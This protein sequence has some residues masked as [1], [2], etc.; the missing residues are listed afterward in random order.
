M[1]GTPQEICGLIH[2]LGGLPK[3]QELPLSYTA[4]KLSFA[5]LNWERS[6][7]QRNPYEPAQRNQRMRT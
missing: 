6:V 4:T 3:K 7:Q 1:E 2:L 5:Q